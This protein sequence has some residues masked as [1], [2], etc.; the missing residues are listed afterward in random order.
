MD[1][2]YTGLTYG[3]LGFTAFWGMIFTIENFVDS[4]RMKRYHL[5]TKC[6]EELKHVLRLLSREELT[7]EMAGAKPYEIF[8]PADVDTRLFLQ[9]QRD[10]LTRK[11]AKL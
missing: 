9:A 8:V 4:R 11:L 10:I 3:V 2:F 1:D 7:R 6:E 5:R